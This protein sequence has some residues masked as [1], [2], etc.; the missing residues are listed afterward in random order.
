[1]ALSTIIAQLKR[2]R[3]NLPEIPAW[4]VWIG[5]RLKRNEDNLIKGVF[6]KCYQEPKIYGC[7]VFSRTKDD[8]FEK[9]KSFITFFNSLK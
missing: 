3:S 4:I 6:E 9:L 1:M 8:P 2:I 7:I 5:F